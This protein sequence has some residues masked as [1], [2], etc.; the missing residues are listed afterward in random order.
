MMRSRLPLEFWTSKDIV[1]KV[2]NEEYVDID[3]YYKKKD[4]AKYLDKIIK[5]NKFEGG[6]EFDKQ[7]YWYLLKFFFINSEFHDID[8]SGLSVVNLGV[9]SKLKIGCK[10]GNILED[11]NWLKGYCPPPLA[12][13]MQ[14]NVPEHEYFLRISKPCPKCNNVICIYRPKGGVSTLLLIFLNFLF[15]SE[16]FHIFDPSIFMQWLMVISKVVDFKGVTDF[17]YEDILKILDLI[18]SNP[19]LD[20]EYKQASKYRFKQI[21]GTFD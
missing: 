19:N 15:P 10:C 13:T 4:R 5:K 17:F 1:F 8:P 6:I 20:E 3:E 21:L 9:P 11:S 2:D 16:K 12:Q 14:K 18:D 7:E